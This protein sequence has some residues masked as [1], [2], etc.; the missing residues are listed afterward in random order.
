MTEPQEVITRGIKYL[1]YTTDNYFVFNKEEINEISHNELLENETKEYSEKEK[2][3]EDKVNQYYDDRSS[4]RIYVAWNEGDGDYLN[5]ITL[6]HMMLNRD[7][8]VMNVYLRSVD[9]AKLISDL[10]FLC[11]LAVKY[12]I[13]VL[14][15]LIGSLH[16]CIE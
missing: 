15:V 12:E 4:R 16:T 6:I 8:N 13:D 9:T 5:C 3:I 2:A 1:E 11:K 10:S 14:Q 7:S